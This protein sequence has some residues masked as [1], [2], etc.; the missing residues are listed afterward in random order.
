MSPGVF[1]GRSNVDIGTAALC[2][3]VMSVR[4]H[5]LHVLSTAS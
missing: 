1:A 3:C 5:N 4:E 2:A